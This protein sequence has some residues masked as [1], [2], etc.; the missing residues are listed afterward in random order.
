MN[1]VVSLNEWQ[2]RAVSA[3]EP[4]RDDLDLA[5][6]LSADG[7]RKVDLRWLRSGQ[8]EVTSYSWIGVV[9]LSGFTIQI[10]PKFAGYEL[11]VLK[12]LE[13]ARD[14]TSATRLRTERS[15]DASG[16]NLL[17]LLCMLL[18]SEATVILRDGLLFDYTERTEALPAL[19]GSL[20]YREQ[21]T[22]RF[23]Q[24]DVLECQ[25]DE[26]HADVLD[27]QLLLAGL[28]I[29]GRVSG[30]VELR[31]KLR[32]LEHSV[33]EL[34]SSGP[35]DAGHYRLRLNY[36][37][38]NER[39]RRAHTLAL[40]LIETLG[41]SDL[42]SAGRV[43]SFAFLLDMNKVFEDFVTALID[44]AFK[45][46]AWHVVPQRRVHSVVRHRSG[47]RYS[48]IIPDLVLSNR[49][50]I[51]PFDCKYK[52]YGAGGRRISSGDIYQAFVYAYAL[53]GRNAG[54]A[55]AGILF[56]AERT[57]ASPQ[58]EVAQL[59]GPATAS[60]TGI[61]IDLIGVLNAMGSADWRSTLQSVCDVVSTVL[62]K[63]A[64]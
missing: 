26:F 8:L 16:E 5:A 22:K 60:L 51:V 41:I 31:R 61:A 58:L 54:G 10:R 64:E 50:E 27:N 3:P 53:S 29:A 9:R 12:M 13:Y 15:F 6:E 25:F 32:R 19:R 59:D 47:K 62:E 57:A 28:S 33:A 42:Y 4:S 49:D 23:G 24:L 21:S 20:R 46:A 52:L 37:R 11:G 45:G 36:T 34:S 35:I 44:E 38:R 40:M 18:A 48:T 55:R 43:E 39:Y 1:S 30:R 17:D 2:T 56:P 14:I 63:V 7:Q